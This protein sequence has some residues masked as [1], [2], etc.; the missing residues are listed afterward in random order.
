MAKVPKSC[1]PNIY[2]QYDS[3]GNRQA[4]KSDKSMLVTTAVVGDKIATYKLVKVETV[5]L[6]V[7]RDSD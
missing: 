1:S 6:A 2:V 4:M 5:G 3:A 7:E